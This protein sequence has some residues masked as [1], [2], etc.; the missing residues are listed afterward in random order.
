MSDV[1]ADARKATFG[2][3][4]PHEHKKGWKCKTLKMVEGGWCYDPAPDVEDGVTCFYCGLSLDGW[5][6]KDNPLY[7]LNRAVA[8]CQ[9]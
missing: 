7:V 6:P 1:M 8:F 5:E 2:D 9:S 3:S 4:W